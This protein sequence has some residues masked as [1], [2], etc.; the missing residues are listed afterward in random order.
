MKRLVEGLPR[1][2][3][4]CLLFWALLVKPMGAFTSIHEVGTSDCCATKD[5]FWSEKE[6]LAKEG[7]WGDVVVFLLL[8]CATFAGDAIIDGAGKASS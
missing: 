5:R 7:N 4:M 2:P 1:L 6:G 8:A 3:S